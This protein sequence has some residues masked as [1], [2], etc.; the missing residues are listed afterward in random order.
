MEIWTAFL[1][2][3]L[4]SFHC[5]GMCGPIVL[6]L[7]SQQPTKLTYFLSRIVYNFGRVITYSLMGIII[8]FIGQSISLAGYQNYLSVSMGILILIMVLI[9]TGYLN[10]VFP[11]VP[12]DKFTSIIKKYWGRLFGKSKIS[13]LFLI[14]ILNGFLPCGF[15]YI[16]LAGAASTGSV[17]NSW[18]Y[19]VLFGIGT[20]PI[21]LVTSFAGKLIS[22]NLKATFN[23]LIPI[24]G[25]V[26]AVLIILRGLSLGIPYISPK[27]S[28]E[29]ST[30]EQKMEC[31]HPA[32][33]T[34]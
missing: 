2:G 15:V 23:K 27:I 12:F 34:K 32:D 13:S 33:S 1:F 31:C 20:I 22:T 16:A 17:F 10:K 4:G 6:A 18:L 24:G 14:G 29:H 7:P 19:M 9:P 11:F 25:I 28:V 30:G 21:L 8:G 5:V 26:L 3:F